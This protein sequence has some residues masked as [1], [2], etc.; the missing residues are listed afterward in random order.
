MIPIDH[1]EMLFELTVEIAEQWSLRS[2]GTPVQPEQDWRVLVLASGQEIELCTIHIQILSALDRNWC[3]G[4]IRL[5]TYASHEES[6]Q[7]QERDAPRSDLELRHQM[8]CGLCHGD[9]LQS[10][11]T[12]Y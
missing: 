7:Y 2:T 1:N 12:G 10:S 11:I 9:L 3:I 8:S 4:C 5:S 6:G